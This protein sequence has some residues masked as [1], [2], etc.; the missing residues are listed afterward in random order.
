[1]YERQDGCCAICGKRESESTRKLA[2]D[3][4]HKTGEIFGLLCG[5]CNHRFVSNRREPEKYLKAYQYLSGGTG[6]FIKN[7]KRVKASRK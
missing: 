7:V 2:V 6:L 5:W 3:H 4:D 1:M